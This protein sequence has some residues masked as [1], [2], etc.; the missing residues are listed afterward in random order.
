MQCWAFMWAAADRGTA[1]CGLLLIY[2]IYKIG[3]HHAVPEHAAEN[4]PSSCPACRALLGTP[5][6]RCSPPQLTLRQLVHGGHARHGRGHV[7]V[8]EFERCRHGRAAPQERAGLGGVVRGVRCAVLA[9]LQ[10][11]PATAGCGQ[12]AATT[13]VAG[14]ELWTGVRGLRVRGLRVRGLRA[15]REGAR[16]WWRRRPARPTAGAGSTRP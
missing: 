2:N 13:A 5:V 4:L 11:R 10:G 16:G 3:D 9:P 6:P 8:R 12:S 14:H 15:A 7:S 1:G